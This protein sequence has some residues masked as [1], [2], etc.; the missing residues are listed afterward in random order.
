VIEASGAAIRSIYRDAFTAFLERW[1]ART[2]G[3]GIDYTLLVTDAP[4][5]EALREF[6]LRRHDLT[7]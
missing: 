3:E 7:G 1:R 5:D 2:R 6:L 4:L